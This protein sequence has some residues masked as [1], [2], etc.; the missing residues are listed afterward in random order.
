MEALA[1]CARFPSQAALLGD[2]DQEDDGAGGTSAAA[3]DEDEEVGL[4]ADVIWKEDLQMRTSL[5]G[6]RPQSLTLK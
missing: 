3:L 1:A 2:S 4:G 5:P 6:L